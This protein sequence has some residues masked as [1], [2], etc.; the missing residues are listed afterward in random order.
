MCMEDVR[1]GRESPGNL[2]FATIGTASTPFLPADPMRVAIRFG[3][4]SAGTIT[5]S[6]ETISAVGNGLIVSTSAPGFDLDVK[7]HGD[8]VK[9][10]WNARADAAGRL[11]A[12]IVVILPKQ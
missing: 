1:L 4:P 10:A 9:R 6:T 11:I 5:Y 12:A 8:I 3:A 7:T 2:V